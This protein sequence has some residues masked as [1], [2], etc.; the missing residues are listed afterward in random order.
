MAGFLG[1]SKQRKQQRDE[2][3]Q[4]RND[5][6]AAQ[7]ASSNVKSIDYSVAGGTS[8]GSGLPASRLSGRETTPEPSTP[9]PTPVSAGDV[10][11][12]IRLTQ[13]QA[14]AINISRGFPTAV[15]AGDVR[16]GIRLTGSQAETFNL[17]RG[18]APIPTQTIPSSSQFNLPSNSSPRP[19]IFTSQ[20]GTPQ[21]SQPS[22]SGFVW[23]TAPRGN[24]L[25]N[26][27]ASTPTS[28]ADVLSAI[29]KPS[30]Q[31][32]RIPTPVITVSPTS[33]LNSITR[34]IYTSSRPGIYTTTPSKLDVPDYSS[35]RS[36]I[37]TNKTPRLTNMEMINKGYEKN[38]GYS[39]EVP[40]L[41][42]STE[43]GAAEIAASKAVKGTTD[44]LIRLGPDPLGLNVEGADSKQVL[45]AQER[46]F[47]I[48]QDLESK[49]NLNY[50]SAWES[51]NPYS[52]EGAI[53]K[54]TIAAVKAGKTYEDYRITGTGQKGLTFI[55][56]KTDFVR[57]RPLE[58]AAELAIIYYTGKTL[59]TAHTLLGGAGGTVINQVLG[60]GKAAKTAKFLMDTKLY[61]EEGKALGYVVEESSLKL[62]FSEKAAKDTAFSENPNFKDDS[63]TT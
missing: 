39:F 32:N 58:S 43:R 12:G 28:A 37:F 14:D 3:V 62:G 38:L 27:G 21:P 49:G 22:G 6:N 60:S 61:I 1:T 46:K 51:L 4:K 15:S 20:T 7:K 26:V 48:A 17:S 44:F 63:S 8:P 16:G 13:Q 45:S 5:A 9:T 35:S 42:P 24:L 53:G 59:A 2:A 19:G 30:T 23:A 40:M 10:R 57:E 11:G 56:A 55:S 52:V 18:F 36:D 31:L 34:P 25:A 47:K 33:K 54:E 29:D 41:K 50:P